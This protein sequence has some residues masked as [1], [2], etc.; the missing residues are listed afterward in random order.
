MVSPIFGADKG[1][2]SLWK[3]AR[4]FGTDAPMALGADKGMV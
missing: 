2:V 3:G 4:A 1:M